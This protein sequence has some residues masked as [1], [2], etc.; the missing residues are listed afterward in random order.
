MTGV[1]TEPLVF[2][3]GVRAK[4]RV[5][6][7]PMTNQQSAD[8]GTLSDAELA[9]LVMRARGSFAVVETC[10]AHVALDGQGWRGEL[11]VYDDRLLARAPPA[12]VGDHRRRGAR[13]RA[14]SSTEA[15]APR[16]R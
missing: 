16:R 3:N 12:R 14:G 11:G 9:W 1:L 5:W 10:A 15:S 2:R 7:A 13:L 8:D 4:N 6:L